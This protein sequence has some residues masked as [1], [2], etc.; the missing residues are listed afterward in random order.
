MK[1]IISYSLPLLLLGGCTSE[2]PMVNLGIDDEY[3]I[4]RMSKLALESA[5][6]GAEYRWK[7]NGETVSTDRRYIFL[8]QHEGTYDLTFDIIDEQTPYHFDFT[9]T[10]LHEEVEYSPYI[11]RVYEYHPAPGQFINEMPKYEA[12]DTYQDMLRKCEE[13]ISGTNDI[14][15]SLGAYGG[16]VT[17][18]FDH[19]VINVA[20]EK[21]F[22][23]WGNAFYE[24][25]NPDDKGGSAEPGIVMV[26][27]DRN[28]NG[29]PD[30]EWYELAG[31]E[32]YK[33]ET[34]HGYTITYRRP[35]PTQKPEEDETG[36]LDNVR[37]IPW[38][39]SEGNSGYLA[40]NIFHAQSYYPLWTADDEITFRGTRLAPNG[41]DLSGTGRYYVLYA[42]DWGYVDNH[43][44]DFAD[45]NSFD[46]SWAVDRDGKPVSLPGIDFVRVYTGLSQYC[47]WLGETSTEISGARD[48]HVDLPGVPL[49]EIP[50]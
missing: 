9:V 30:D 42:Y 17:F 2:I 7:V 3:Y 36:F 45:L 16:Y 25:T 12:G 41:I 19:T 23:I 34:L 44:N 48:L 28:C 49:P 5:L 27:Y 22:R 21:D 14:M 29:L 40:K 1:R 31:S 6:T 50:L 46:I 4:P 11:S 24:L 47:G 26:S 20:G 33:P 35:D 38:S 18:G 10:V 39:D 15:I 43:P 37:Y 8:A 32:Y 13:S